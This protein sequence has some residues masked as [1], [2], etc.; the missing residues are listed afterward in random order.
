MSEA[1]IENQKSITEK[2]HVQAENLRNLVQDMRRNNQ[3][4][5][6]APGDAHMENILNS[7]EH[8]LGRNRRHSDLKRE[9]DEIQ[10]WVRTID[11]KAKLTLTWEE[12]DDGDEA[13]H[14]RLHLD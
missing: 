9:N 7:F 11:E 4:T 5:A 1:S 6:V 14:L 12:G 10:A 13:W 8:S 2:L 3:T